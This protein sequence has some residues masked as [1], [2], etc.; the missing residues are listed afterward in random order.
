MKIVGRWS[1]LLILSV[2]LLSACY[3]TSKKPIDVSQEFW[4]EGIQLSILIN[5]EN[6][7]S[8]VRYLEG[9]RSGTDDEY[10]QNSAISIKVYEWGRQKNLS[11][12]E[13]KIAGKVISLLMSHGYL[14][15]SVFLETMSEEKIKDYSKKYKD[16]EK[17][18]GKSNLIADD[19]TG[20]YLEKIVMEYKNNKSEK[21]EQPKQADSNQETETT[22][23]NKV[24]NDWLSL[25]ENEKYHAVSNAL[26]NLDQQGYTI[27]EGEYYYI[28]VLD[29]FYSGGSNS[30]VS[31]SK[32]L[33]QIGVLSGTIYR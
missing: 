18:F 15:S 33:A 30:S 7:A 26:F 5:K 21:S 3:S 10:N 32:A 13:D 31:V 25:N 6:E 2:I 24:G 16:V 17:L 1:I 22:I 19:K 4:D 12:K 28:D 29:A 23:D 11:A 14:E 27:L 9:V 8:L 20:D